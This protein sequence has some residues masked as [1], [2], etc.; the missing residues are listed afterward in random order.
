[1]AVEIEKKYRLTP[2]QTELI[3]ASLNRLGAEFTG[4]EFE[5]NTIYGG[6]PL[7]GQNA[8]LRVRHTG[9]RTILTF[10][11]RIGSELPVKQ[12]IEYESEVGD[13]DAIASIL[14]SLGLAPR[15][16]Y[17]KRRRT[18]RSRSAEIV[19]DELPF[20]LYMEIE[21]SVTAIAEVEM[22]LDIDDLEPEHE[23]YPRL[24]QQ[25]G[26]RRGTIVESRFRR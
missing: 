19:L 21:G 1:M 6:P 8:I 12:Q 11:K 22:L 2:G 4:E 18:W 14:E 3:S 10:K 23:T 26:E 5:E 20:G 13:A 17:E 24:T 9:D 7:D 15:L 25:H 16:V